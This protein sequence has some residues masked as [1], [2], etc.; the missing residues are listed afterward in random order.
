MPDV[1]SN[2]DILSKLVALPIEFQQRK[3]PPDR[4]ENRIDKSD[5][6]LA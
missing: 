3:Q 2:P 4:A 1:F 5:S 6:H